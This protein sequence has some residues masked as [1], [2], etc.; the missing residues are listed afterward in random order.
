[1]RTASGSFCLPRPFPTH[2]LTNSPTHQLTNSLPFRARPLP[3]TCVLNE[4]DSDGTLGVIAQDG[5]EL[6]RF[7]VVPGSGSI[8]SRGRA[9]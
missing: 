6:K 7:T 3:L 2:Q 1:M 9:R 8:D 5:S 4:E